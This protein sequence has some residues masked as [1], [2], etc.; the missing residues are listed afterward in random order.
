MTAAPSA[1][2]PPTRSPES[3]RHPVVAPARA[4]QRPTPRGR[5]EPWLR[6]S[7][8]PRA[9]VAPTSLSRT[10]ER[11][12]HRAHHARGL[13][14]L[15]RRQRQAIRELADEQAIDTAIVGD[16]RRA[17][18]R[19]RQPHRRRG[20]RAASASSRERADRSASDGGDSA[21]MDRTSMPA[22]GERVVECARERGIR[23]TSTTGLPVARRPPSDS[24]S[25][26]ATMRAR[27]PQRRYHHRVRLRGMRT[28]IVAPGRRAVASL[29]CKPEAGTA[30]R[31]KPRRHRVL[32]GLGARPRRASTTRS[33]ARTS[34]ASRCA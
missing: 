13:R 11:T 15:R 1:V 30:A 17:R 34:T 14:G 29:P 2:R 24:T 16:E 3:R 23:A 25:T 31:A 10:R 4:N 18:R 7:P 12:Q 21:P 20:S 27:T 8:G 19:R 5:G 28:L 6:G 33:R 22:G 32:A 26:S 9:A